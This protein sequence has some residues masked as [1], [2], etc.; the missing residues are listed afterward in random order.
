MLVLAAGCASAAAAA[1]GAA[2]TAGADM[3]VDRFMAMLMM[4][5]VTEYG[6]AE[7]EDDEEEE[8]DWAE[9]EGNDAREHS[10]EDGCAATKNLS[11]LGQAKPVLLCEW[12]KRWGAALPERSSNPGSLTQAAKLAGGELYSVIC[13]IYV[14]TVCTMY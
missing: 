12:G 14:K 6:V 4:L 8:Q 9:D 13:I 2:A 10:E 5:M 1:S 11:S 3:V 7:N